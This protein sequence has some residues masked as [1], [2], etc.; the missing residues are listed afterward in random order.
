MSELQRGQVQAHLGAQQE[1]SAPLS[2]GTWGMMAAVIPVTWH[3]K[4]LVS[5]FIQGT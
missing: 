5:A 2:A 3:V 1:P 4:E